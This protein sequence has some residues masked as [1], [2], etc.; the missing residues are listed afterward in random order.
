LSVSAYEVSQE[1]FHL[2]QIIPDDVQRDG[3]HLVRRQAL[4]G[5]IQDDRLELAIGFDLRRPVHGEI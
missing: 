4:N 1:I 5:G 2:P 3:F